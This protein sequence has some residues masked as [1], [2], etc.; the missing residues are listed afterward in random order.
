MD[1]Q[2]LCEITIK[3][4]DINKPIHLLNHFNTEKKNKMYIFKIN[5]QPYSL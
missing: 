4:E 1:N 2:I 3:K 5:G